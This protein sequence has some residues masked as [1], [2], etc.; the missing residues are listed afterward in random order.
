LSVLSGVVSN[1]NKSVLSGFVGFV[2]FVGFC[3][4]RRCHR[5]IVNA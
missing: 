5:T 1:R 4:K 2:G 3:K